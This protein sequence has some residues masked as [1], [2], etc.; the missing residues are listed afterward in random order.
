MRHRKKGRK[1]GRKSGP[2][3]ALKRSIVTALFTHGRIETTLPKA[4]EYR[5]AAEKLI[6]LARRSNAAKAQGDHAA[7]LHGY[8]RAIAA[9][10]GNKS[11]QVLAKQLFEEIAPQF[12]DRNGGYTRVIR[13]AKGR[14]GDNA[15]RALFELVG[16]TP[17]TDDSVDDVDAD[18]EETAEA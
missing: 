1:F 3:K 8:R 5:S 11:S 4:K 18:V 17:S 15:P 7:W 10:G 12:E 9:L 6:T 14:L 13:M 16:Y 2:R